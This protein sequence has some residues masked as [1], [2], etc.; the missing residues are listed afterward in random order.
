MGQTIGP[1]EA[2]ARAM[3][4]AQFEASRKKTK[5]TSAELKTAIASVPAKKAPKVKK[6]RL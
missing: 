6:K 1:K 2:A 5:A 3:R 4:E